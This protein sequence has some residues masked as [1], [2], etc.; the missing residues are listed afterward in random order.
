MAHPARHR[1][2]RPEILP[3]GDPM[4]GEQHP[5]RLKSLMDESSGA[6]QLA[7]CEISACRCPLDVGRE[8][9]EA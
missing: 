9:K 7:H 4:F 5:P 1:E 6:G 2:Q 8:L 3:S